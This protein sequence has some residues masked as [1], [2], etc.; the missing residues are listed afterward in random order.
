MARGFRA[1]SA[2]RSTRRGSGSGCACCSWRR[3]LRRPLRMLHLDL[4]VLL[5]FSVSYAF[6]GAG[7]P[8][9]LG[10]HRPIRCSLYLLGAD[11]VDRR[12]RGR[13]TPRRC[14]SPLP[15]GAP[16][17]RRS[18]SSRLPHRA[19]HHERQRDRRRLRG[20]GRRR[21]PAPRRARSTAASRPTTRTAT[22]TGR[23]P[24]PP[25]SRSCS[26]L[27]VERGRGTTCPRRTPRRSRSTSP[28]SAGLWLAGR[29][30]GGPL[31]GLLLAYLWAAFPFTLL[32]ANSGAN[33][34]LVAA[35]V[36]AAFLCLGRPAARGRAR[37]ARR[38][39]E[40]R[41]ARARAAVRHLRRTA[42]GCAAALAARWPPVLLV[43]APVALGPA[44][45]GGSGTGRSASRP[46]RARRSRSGAST[47][48]STRLQAG[49]T[50]AAAALALAVAFVPRR[51]DE[52]RR[53]RRSARRC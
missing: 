51:R 46:S 13:P 42:A 19:E 1:S 15:D 12:S 45:R 48:G 27:A 47:A 25:T 11:A 50:V 31:L 4:A 7:E 10:P 24:T 16:A 23:S 53:S 35:L 44:A 41:A 37:G 32:V 49:V 30:L 6:F 52:R 2:A 5:A 36:L 34:A 22:P 9:R 39:D 17:A 28:A 14:G 38:P 20:R 8:R 29:R 26:L 3:S 33:D 43:L 40:V 18:S 21:P